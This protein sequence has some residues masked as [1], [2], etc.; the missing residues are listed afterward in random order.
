MW[1]PLIVGDVAQGY[2]QNKLYDQ[3]NNALQQ[4]LTNQKSY[5]AQVDKAIQGL[6]GNVGKDTPAA[7]EAS[8]MDDYRKALDSALPTGSNADINAGGDY[9]KGAA[10]ELLGRKAQAFNLA[11]ELAKV[12]AP[13]TMRRQEGYQLADTGN[14]ADMYRNFAGGSHGV[15]EDKLKGMHLDPGY[16]MII[17]ALQQLGSYGMSHPGGTPQNGQAG[18]SGASGQGSFG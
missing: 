4:D 1:I 17:G 9:S 10:Q 18:A 2:E 13:Q 6:L 16:Q 5:Q 11:G 8:S 3:E 12:S 14:T 7:A 15:T